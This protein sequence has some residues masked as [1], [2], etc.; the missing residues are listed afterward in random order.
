MLASKSVDIVLR[1]DKGLSWLIDIKGA[2]GT[3]Y[4]GDK[5]TL[6]FSFLGRYP[7][8]SPV[9]VFVGRAPVHPHIYSNGHICLSILYNAWS[10]ALSVEA[11]CQ[12]I[13]SMMSA[14][15]VKKPPADDASYCRNARSKN[16]SP[17]EINWGFDD[18]RA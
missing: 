16:W 10:P 8:E 15:K 14:A 3:C 4:Q 11:V 9:V 12:S 13:L 6:Q 17:K 1:E 7:I 5:F 18:D 2:P